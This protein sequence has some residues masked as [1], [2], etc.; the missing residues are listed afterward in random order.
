M[1]ETEMGGARRLPA[2]LDV[3]ASNVHSRMEFHKNAYVDCI[4]I[5]NALHCVMEEKAK[6]QLEQNSKYP[7]VL[8]GIFISF[9]M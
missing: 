8:V 6:L 7:C 9:R 2:S 4:G 5:N 1:A 3:L